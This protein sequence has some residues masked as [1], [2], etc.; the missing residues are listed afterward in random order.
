MFIIAVAKAQNNRDIEKGN[1]LERYWSQNKTFEG[2]EDAWD[3]AGGAK[4]LFDDPAMKK[5][6]KIGATESKDKPATDSMTPPKELPRG[7]TFNG[8]SA[9][10]NRLWRLPNG[11]IKEELQ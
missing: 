9:N 6:S 5:F 11:K 4:S 2:G 8:H 10:G 3:T 7:T 1:F